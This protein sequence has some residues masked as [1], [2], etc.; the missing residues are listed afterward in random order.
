M[1]AFWQG[2]GDV[3]AGRRS[4][5]YREC[6]PDGRVLLRPWWWRLMPRATPRQS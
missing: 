5:I 2:W 1:I 4:A 6:H 3:L